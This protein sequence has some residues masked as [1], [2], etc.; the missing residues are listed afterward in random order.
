MFY[1]S[2]VNFVTRT[3]IAICIIGSSA[4]NIASAEEANKHV[5]K[6]SASQNIGV[7]AGD[8]YYLINKDGAWSV[9][10]AGDLSDKNV[11]AVSLSPKTSAQTIG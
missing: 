4:N 6:Y 7:G 5:L 2:G 11:E 1:E 9:A 3:A 8:T 10:K